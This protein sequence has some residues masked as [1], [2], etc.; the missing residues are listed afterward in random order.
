MSGPA[1]LFM[2]GCPAMFR[3]IRLYER[4]QGLS[5]GQGG[6][7]EWSIW[8]QE[9]SF[10]TS[11]R[12]DGRQDR[13]AMRLQP[14]CWRRRGQ[15]CAW[16]WVGSGPLWAWAGRP[17]SRGESQS[18]KAMIG[19]QG[20]VETR[21][22]KCILMRMFCCF[23]AF[24]TAQRFIWIKMGAWS[25]ARWEGLGLAKE[26]QVERRVGGGI[27]GGL[28]KAGSCWRVRSQ[29]WRHHWGRLGRGE[30]TAAL[31]AWAPDICC[32]K[33]RRKPEGNISSSTWNYSIER[34]I[35]NCKTHSS[36]YQF[37]SGKR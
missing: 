25:W 15:L 36:H 2:G 30:T 10:L 7:C 23:C 18:N 17:S 3:T 28:V 9:S 26:R 22:Y 31:W 6:G 37:C 35:L 1:S 19:L 24:A 8:G 16:P 33:H 27:H 5:T 12:G 4:G 11:D 14:T 32:K 29:R 13:P 21:I 20:Q 34:V